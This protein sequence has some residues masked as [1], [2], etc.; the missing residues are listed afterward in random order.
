M[1]YANTTYQVST[2]VQLLRV[3][4]QCQYDRLE[5]SADLGGTCVSSLFFGN[6][7]ESSQGSYRQIGP[8]PVWKWNPML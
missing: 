5:G 6:C 3:D 1:V 4:D 2:V 8:F 7:R